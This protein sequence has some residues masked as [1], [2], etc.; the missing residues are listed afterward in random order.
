MY[1]AYLEENIHIVEDTR[2][3]RLIENIPRLDEIDKTDL[4]KQYHP[5]YIKSSMRKLQVG[6]NKGGFT[7][8]ELADI[9]EGNSRI[10]PEKI[11]PSVPTI[12]WMCW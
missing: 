5:D 1:P 3:R 9:L 2:V 11:D 6:V 12:M 8:V 7:P 4:L 10:D